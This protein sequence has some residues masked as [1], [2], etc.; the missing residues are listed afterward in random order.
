MIRDFNVQ[1][2]QRLER[3]YEKIKSKETRVHKLQCDIAESEHQNALKPA[4]QE[5][6]KVSPDNP[7]I[8]T[9]LLLEQLPGNQISNLDGFTSEEDELIIEFAAWYT[10][11]NK[12]GVLQIFIKNKSVDQILNRWL[13]LTEKQV[14]SKKLVQFEPYE[15]NIVNN[16]LRLH[17]LLSI[18]HIA[19]HLPKRSMQEVKLYL[20]ENGFSFPGNIT[21]WHIQNDEM[22]KACFNRYG[23]NLS[24]YY[25]RMRHINPLLIRHRLFSVLLKD[26]ISPEMFDEPNYFGYVKNMQNADAFYAPKHE[27]QVDDLVN[28]YYGVNSNKQNRVSADDFTITK[29]LELEQESEV[30]IVVDFPLSQPV[31]KPPPI[32]KLPLPIQIEQSVSSK[33]ITIDLCDENDDDVDKNALWS[34]SSKSSA[35]EAKQYKYQS[36]D[37]MW[38]N[39]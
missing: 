30:Q 23:G 39:Q 12:W 25:N 29:S 13:K 34:Q 4:S 16:I 15:K 6:E 36:W 31:T 35:G 2:K 17:G 7:I 10:G 32:E 28:G 19:K 5:N 9:G 33:S 37:D 27:Q 38:L 3:Q 14:F 11:I 21:N 24:E 22:L 26:L 20:I 1:V 8:N 18:S